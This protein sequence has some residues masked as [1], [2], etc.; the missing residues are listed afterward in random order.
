M[1]RQNKKKK[2]KKNS[3]NRILRLFTKSS[4]VS[5]YGDLKCAFKANCHTFFPLSIT[6]VHGTWFYESRDGLSVRVWQGQCKSVRVW[7]VSVRVSSV[8]V[9][10]DANVIPYISSSLCLS[11]L[12]TLRRQSSQLKVEAGSVELVLKAREQELA[13]IRLQLREA[14]SRIEQAAKT[15]AEKSRYWPAWIQRTHS[16]SVYRVVFMIAENS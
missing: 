16:L 15:S 9:W 13:D 4:V 8:L 12:T 11:E 7:Q 3:R 6:L 14:E 10:V 2:T 1:S 5:L